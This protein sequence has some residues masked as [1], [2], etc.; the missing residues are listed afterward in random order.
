MSRT[1]LDWAKRNL[2]LNGLAG[3]AHDFVQEDCLQWLDEQGAAPRQRYG[4]IFVDPPTL[5]RSKRMEREFDVQRDHV[6]L[7]LAA[8]RLLEPGGVLL[9]SNN[10]QRFR[11]DDHSLADFEI[12]DVSRETLPEDFKRNPRIHVCFELRHRRPALAGA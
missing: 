12:R 8:G 2:A 5:S 11:L 1:Y 6:D 7:L 10:F 9:F 4:L 3:P